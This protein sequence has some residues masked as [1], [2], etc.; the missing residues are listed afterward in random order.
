MRAVVLHHSHTSYPLYA[1]AG[2]CRSFDKMP[3]R[4]S[5]CT[6]R[7]PLLPREW[8][9]KGQSVRRK[10]DKRPSGQ[11]RRRHLEI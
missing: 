8:E 10:P 6:A 9:P 4:R 5:H 7:I 3:S 2:H 1:G 11:I